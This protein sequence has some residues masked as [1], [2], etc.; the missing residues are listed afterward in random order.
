M[1]NAEGPLLTIVFILKSGL[2]IPTS[3]AHE[4]HKP[5]SVQPGERGRDSGRGEIRGKL[6]NAA[7]C[8]CVSLVL[9]F[10]FGVEGVGHHSYC[11]AGADTGSSMRHP[12]ASDTHAS[13]RGSW[14]ETQTDRTVAPGSEALI[15]PVQFSS[16]SNDNEGPCCNAVCLH[17]VVV[18]IS[19]GSKTESPSRTTRPVLL[20]IALPLPLLRPLLRSQNSDPWSLIPCPV[21][22]LRPEGHARRHLPVRPRPW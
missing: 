11:S 15:D 6:Q 22:S 18:L 9:F 1:L 7:A 16:H 10:F 17:R 20:C 5:L 2:Y 13:V 4:R 8:M 3:Q 14:A 21:R 12:G 19:S